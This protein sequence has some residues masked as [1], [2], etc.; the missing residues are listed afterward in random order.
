MSDEPNRLKTKLR[1]FLEVLEHGT[2][3][4]QFNYLIVESANVSLWDFRARVLGGQDYSPST[5][6]QIGIQMLQAINDAFRCNIVSRLGKNL[7]IMFGTDDISRVH[8]RFMLGKV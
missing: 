2:V 6:A 7:P 5:A 8:L 1:H 3:D 4:I